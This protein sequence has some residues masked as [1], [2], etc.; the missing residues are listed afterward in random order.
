MTSRHSDEYTFLCY[1]L[2]ELKNQENQ[3]K[4]QKQKIR[5][6]PNREPFNITEV[7]LNPNPYDEKADLIAKKAIHD[8]F[9]EGEFRPDRDSK[10]MKI[11]RKLG[12]KLQNLK[13]SVDHRLQNIYWSNDYDACEEDI[14]IVA[15]QNDEFVRRFAYELTLRLRHHIKKDRQAVNDDLF[16][17]MLRQNGNARLTKNRKNSTPN[18]EDDNV[19]WENG[20]TTHSVERNLLSNFFS[21]IFRESNNFTKDITKEL[22]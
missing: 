5:Q 4:G 9:I 22:I 7:H 10:T 1:E 19:S 15:E 18:S 8:S 20:R 21:Q 12:E 3:R 13:R 14:K 6:N 16:K 17:E 11:N 2:K